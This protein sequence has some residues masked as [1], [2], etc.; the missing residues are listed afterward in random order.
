M[1][2]ARTCIATAIA[3][4]GCL[5]LALAAFSHSAY[6]QV[7]DADFWPK[8]VDAVVVNDDSARDE[9]AKQIADA[10][11]DQ[12]GLTGERRQS[13]KDELAP[14]IA[15]VIGS[16]KVRDAT[17]DAVAQ[18][19][20]QIVTRINNP[21]T[22]DRP[23]VVDLSGVLKPV[24]AESG[25]P[26]LRRMDSLE[27]EVMSADDAADFAQVMEGADDGTS[28]ILWLGL[29]LCGI[30]LLI[31]A[32]RLKLLTRLGA[33]LVLAGIVTAFAWAAT[34]SAVTSGIADD[35]ARNTARDVLGDGFSDLGDRGW[36]MIGVGVLMVLGS[37]ALR[38]MRA[39][40]AERADP[41]MTPVVAAS[42]P[43][44]A[45]TPAPAKASGSAE[46]PARR[47]MAPPTD[48]TKASRDI[49]GE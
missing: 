18:A 14:A 21:G 19:Q 44:S 34:A 11:V 43:M 40:R 37:I 16:K 8:A 39:Q 48:L 46:A 5:V 28:W 24:A 22:R 35:A 30:A 20:R 10:I 29:G 7:F 36:L 41:P 47:V 42:A 45:P 38:V 49:F 2:S 25:L 4:V 33:G 32:D 1:F 23:V 31:A 27:F 15:E 12:E 26:Q 3:W 9:Y 13:A 6:N 17:R